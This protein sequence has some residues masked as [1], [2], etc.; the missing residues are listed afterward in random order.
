MRATVGDRE[1]KPDPKN[2]GGDA[3]VVRLLLSKGANPN[4]NS[5]GL[6]PF[7]VAAGVGAGYVTGATGLAMDSSTGGPVNK[8]VMELLLQNGADVNAQVTGTMTYSMR[9]SRAPSANEGRTALHIAA[10]KGRPIWFAT[11]FRK[12]RAPEIKDAGGLKPIDLLPGGAQGT[13]APPLGAPAAGA[14]KPEVASEIRSLLQSTA[15]KK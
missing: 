10:R 8:E 3:E 12:A 7:L 9:I 13:S 4:I 11:F 2:I 14:V 15:S 6:T 1:P 5:A